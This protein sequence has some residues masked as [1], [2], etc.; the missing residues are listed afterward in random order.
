MMSALCEVWGVLHQ[1][2]SMDY[3]GI[4]QTWEQ[5]NRDGP[6]KNNFLIS[7]GVDILRTKD[8]SGKPMIDRIK[9]KVVQDVDESEGTGAWTCKEGMALHIPIPT[10]AAAHQFRLASAYEHQRKLANKA[11]G[12]RIAPIGSCCRHVERAEI[13][14]LCHSALYSSFLAAFIQGL[15]LLAK[16]DKVHKWGIDFVTVIRIWRAGCIIRSESIA[17]LLQSVYE[18]ADEEVRKFLLAHEKIAA[19]FKEHYS[20]L[21]TFVK[22]A[23]S[24]DA[25]IPAAS[26]TLEYLKYSFVKDELPTEF[27]EVELDYFGGH[28]FELKGEAETGPAT[29]PYHFG[30]HAAKSVPEEKKVSK[31]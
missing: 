21:K 16:A 3:E 31:I 9:D 4:A 28:N 13:S 10:I 14:K 24:A 17:D 29:G 6:L 11:L 15:T 8:E 2:I 26:A 22:E 12:G 5:W 1:N 30:W 7:I 18:G 19:E 27:M 20:A 25:V 23:T